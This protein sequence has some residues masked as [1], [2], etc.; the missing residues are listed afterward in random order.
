VP[1]VPFIVATTPVAT[2][3]VEAKLT[4]M[5]TTPNFVEV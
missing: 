2:G 1:E 4:V 3:V 5:L